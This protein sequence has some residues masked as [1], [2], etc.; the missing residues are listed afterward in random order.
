MW[1]MTFEV[2]SIYY[3]ALDWGEGKNSTPHPRLDVQL[4]LPCP[5][6]LS[7]VE[8]GQCWPP[9]C[10]LSLSIKVFGYYLDLSWLWLSVRSKLEL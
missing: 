5:V 6:P 2:T 1:G 10:P 3:C 9:S 8:E 7:P 4:T